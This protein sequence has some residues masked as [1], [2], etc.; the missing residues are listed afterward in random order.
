MTQ[1]TGSGGC[2]ISSFA[3]AGLIGALS[4]IVFRIFAGYLWTQ[5]IFL[6]GLVVVALG[7]V[8]AYI[9][10]RELP[11]L[12]DV[13]APGSDAR[14]AAPKPTVAPAEVK[15]AAPV[16]VPEAARA[17]APDPGEV[18]A[19]GAGTR[20]KALT[21]AREGGA[22]NLKEIKGV[23][24]KLEKLCNNLGFFHF[25]QIA[26]WSPE[27]VAWVD[28]NLEGFKGRVTRDDWVAQAKVL[29]AGGETEFSKKVEDGKVY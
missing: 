2:T 19:S 10:C 20:P 7:V 29:A 12:E 14:P 5:S 18:A 26:A 23:G 28:Q 11:A 25:D 21:A 15:E 24:P 17:A 13:K 3:M 6:G 1:Q 16:E 27:E 8:F 4:I 22:D 9:F